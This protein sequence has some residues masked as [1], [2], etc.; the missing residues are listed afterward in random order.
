MIRRIW[1]WGREAD[2][3]VNQ[4]TE[5]NKRSIGRLRRLFGLVTG[6][7]PG[8]CPGD[9]LDDDLGRYGLGVRRSLAEYEVGSGLNFLA[10]TWQGRA[11]QPGSAGK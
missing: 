2:R 4:W 11:L 5:M 7:V 6:Q 9:V 3:F 1:T 10:R 8:Q